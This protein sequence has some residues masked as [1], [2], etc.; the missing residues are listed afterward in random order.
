M[1]NSLKDRHKVSWHIRDLGK[2]DVN[3]FL[4]VTKW[5]ENNAVKKRDIQRRTV[6]KRMLNR[7]IAAQIGLKAAEGDIA[8]AKEWMDRGEGKVADRLIA[9]HQ[10]T[11]NIRIELAHSQHTLPSQVIDGE[12]V[13]R[14]ALDQQSSEKELTGDQGETGE[15]LSGPITGGS[16]E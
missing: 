3:S 10:K 12:E 5:L 11:V 14:H 15:T 9:D 8:A 16:K 4:E 2:L 13:V 7:L 6:S 1:E